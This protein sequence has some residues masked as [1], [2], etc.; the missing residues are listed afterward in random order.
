MPQLAAAG[1]VGD[2]T[3][4]A[5]EKWSMRNVTIGGHRYTPAFGNNLPGP[6]WKSVMEFMTKD[7]PVQQFA[8]VDNS[9]IH[10]FTSKVPDVRGWTLAKALQ[11]LI[12]AGFSP[13][14]ATDHNAPAIK[15]SKFAN[16]D[17]FELPVLRYQCYFIDRL[18]IA[19]YQKFSV[20]SSND[21]LPVARF[22]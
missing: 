5:A 1:W 18:M 2:P 4:S 20:N 8:K 22:Y 7:M 19:A 12:N 6:I 3:G 11:A 17:R 15:R 13:N 21:D 16:L 10:G 14:L 9:V